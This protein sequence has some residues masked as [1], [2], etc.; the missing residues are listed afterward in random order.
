MRRRDEPLSES[1]RLELV[2]E[3]SEELSAAA[4]WQFAQEHIDGD[5]GLSAQLSNALRRASRGDR[6][7]L[8]EIEAL[9]LAGRDAAAE[10]IVDRFL[11]DHPYDPIP[12]PRLLAKYPTGNI[13]QPELLAAYQLAA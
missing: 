12:P 7:A 8:G 10:A 11:R 5:P 1:A 13:P 9:A 4:F 2:T 3:V 6:D